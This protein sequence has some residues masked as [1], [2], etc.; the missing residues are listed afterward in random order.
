MAYNWNAQ[1][2][3]SA[4]AKVKREKTPEELQQEQYKK[5]QSDFSNW[6]VVG[7]GVLDADLDDSKTALAR[8]MDAV[9]DK[10]AAYDRAYQTM[11]GKNTSQ[12]MAEDL[13]TYL[14][15]FERHG[16]G[17]KRIADFPYGSGGGGGQTQTAKPD[18]QRSDAQI[19][20]RYAG[21]IRKAYDALYQAQG[22]N[23]M[24]DAEAAQ[25]EITRLQNEMAA[26]KERAAAQLMADYMSAQQAKNSAAMSRKAEQIGLLDLEEPSEEIL[27]ENR[28][29]LESGKIAAD[30]SRMLAAEDPIAQL[31]EALAYAQGTGDTAG[32]ETA[33][34]ELTRLTN[35]TQPVTLDD[36]YEQRDQW[37]SE[38]NNT[39]AQLSGTGRATSPEKM[40]QLNA[41]GQQY[42]QLTENLDKIDARIE[43]KE[44]AM[45]TG[46]AQLAL[47]AEIQTYHEWSNV[48]EEELAAEVRVLDDLI[49]FA[50]ARQN[51]YGN[52]TDVLSGRVDKRNTPWQKW[53]DEEARLQELRDEA[54]NRLNEKIRYESTLSD[55]DRAML[56]EV[57]AKRKAYEQAQEAETSARETLEE[58]AKAYQQAKNET[59]KT[60]RGAD[61]YAWASKKAEAAVANY[62]RALAQGADEEE[63]A[64]LYTQAAELMDQLNAA[65]E[66]LYQPYAEAVEAQNAAAQ[67][68]SGDIAAYNMV[69]QKLE[70]RV[71]AYYQAYNNY[72]DNKSGMSEAYHQAYEN[73]LG[74]TALIDG[75]QE[76]LDALY[77]EQNELFMSG[78]GDS[79]RAQEV[80]RLIQEYDAKVVSWM[81]ERANHYAYAYAYDKART[82]AELPDEDRKLFDKIAESGYVG[83]TLSADAQ[84]AQAQLLEK[85][86]EKEYARIAEM[87]QREYNAQKSEERQKGIEK[88]LR[89]SGGSGDVLYSAASVISNIVSAPGALYEIVKQGLENTGT[90]RSIDTNALGFSAQNFTRE[91]RAQVGE[92]LAN[93]GAAQWVNQ[94]AGSEIGSDTARMLYSTLMSG[95]DSAAAMI[96][97]NAL[98]AGLSGLSAVKWTEDAI[99]AVGGY[100]LG[101]TAAA[102]SMQDIAERGGDFVQVMTGGIMAGVFEC[103]FEEVSIEKFYALQETNP[104]SMQ[105]LLGNIVKSMITNAEE[106][107]ATEI[108]NIAYDYLMLGSAS[109]WRTRFEELTQTE[110]LSETQAYKILASEMGSQIGQSALSGAIMGAGFGAV[111]SIPSYI[112]N[113]KTEAF[114][115]AIQNVVNDINAQRYIEIS[116]RNENLLPQYRVDL[117]YKPGVT[118]GEDVQRMAQQVQDAWAKQNAEQKRAETEH[119]QEMAEAK[120]AARELTD[121]KVRTVADMTE[122]QSQAV[123]GTEAGTADAQ[124]AQERRA[125]AERAQEGTRIDENAVSRETTEDTAR[126]ESAQRRVQAQPD[127]EESAYAR[128][129]A[130]DYI[131]EQ[132]Q[133]YKDDDVLARIVEARAQEL[134]REGE[135]G[136]AVAQELRRQMAE[137]RAN[138]QQD[139]AVAASEAPAQPE[140][141]T[142]QTVPSAQAGTAPAAQQTDPEIKEQVNRILDDIIT[143][144]KSDEEIAQDVN[145]RVNELKLAGNDELAEALETEFA[146]EVEEEREVNNGRVYSDRD[147]RR[148]AGQDSAEGR[149][150]VGE[151]TGTAQA[152]KQN[153]A[154]RRQGGNSQAERIAYRV[155][156]AQQKN[157][158]R[159]PMNRI[160]R[161]G[162]ASYDVQDITDTTTDEELV[163]LKKIAAQ[164]G[165]NLRIVLGGMHFVGM[166]KTAN[167][168]FNGLDIVVRA[169]SPSMTATQIYMHEYFHSLAADSPGLVTAAYDALAEA[170]EA[171]GY[172]MDEIDRKYQDAYE[173]AYRNM[174]PEERQI[175]IMEEMC[176]DLYAGFARKVDAPVQA[177]EA[178]RQTV[179]ERTGE[180]Y[181]EARPE[182]TQAQQ[183]TRDKVS[184]EGDD[185][186]EDKY[187]ARQMDKWDSLTDGARIKVGTVKP[188]SALNQVGLPAERMFFDVGKIRKSMGD[189]QDHLTSNVLKQIPDLLNDPIVIAE[190]TRAKN[191]VNVYGNLK[192]ND[193]TPVVVG[194]VMRRDA[195]GSTIINNIRTIHA[196]SDFAKNINDKTV[197]YLNEDRKRTRKWFH[198]CGNLNVPLAGTKFGLIRSISYS[199]DSVKESFSLEEPSDNERAKITSGMSDQE[200][201]DILRQ[202]EMFYAPTYEG[203]AE[204]AIGARTEDLNSGK[205]S[206]IQKAVRQAAAELHMPPELFN[207]D[208]DLV[209]YISNGS[210]DESTKKQIDNAEQLVRL[211]PV[212]QEAVQ[213]AV[214]IEVHDNRYFADYN[215]LYFANLLGGYIDGDYFIPVRFGIKASRDGHNTLYVVISDQAIKKAEVVGPPT[216][217]KPGQNGSRSASD[218]NIAS[219]AKNVKHADILK[220]LPDGMLTE[221]QRELKWKAIADTVVYTNEKNDRKY[222]AFLA[223]GNKANLSAMVQAAAKA[224]GYTV[225]AYHGT[226]RADRVGNVFRPDRATS[227]PMAFFTDSREIAE[228]YS[229]D[230]RDTSLAY[231]TDYDSYET[232]F[233]ARHAKTG[234]DFAIYKLWG[235]IPMS[236]RAKI[237]ERAKHVRIDFDG[238]GEII[239][240]PQAQNANGGW[241]YQVKEFRGDI[242]KA[243]NEQW[244]NSGN[245]FDQEGDYLKV[246]EMVGVN[247]ALRKAGFEMPRYMDPEYREE[248]VYDTYLRIQNPFDAVNM[249]DEDFISGFE[250]F[251]DENEDRF[252]KESAGADYWDKNNVTAEEF[253][254]RMRSD[255]ENGLTHA[256][257]SIPD[258]MTEYLKSLGYDGIKDS[259][260]K[261]GGV[262]HTVW[263]PFESEQVKSADPVTYDDDGKVIPLSERF[264]TEKEDI[265]FALDDTPDSETVTGELTRETEAGDPADDAAKEPTL[266]D[267]IR[268]AA[269]DM[270]LDDWAQKAYDD[271]MA[272]GDKKTADLIRKQRA[273]AKMAKDL[274]REANR[275]RAAYQKDGNGEHLEKMAELRKQANEYAKKERAYAKQTNVKTAPSPAQ[276]IRRTADSIVKMF[277]VRADQRY[278]YRQQLQGVL[279]AIYRKGFV[280]DNDI[281]ALFRAMFDDAVDTVNPD[282]AYEEVAEMM[283]DRHIYVSDEVRAEFGDDWESFRRAMWGTGMIASSNDAD[284]EVDDYYNELSQKN[285]GIFDPE[286]ADGAVQLQAIYDAVKLGK[287]KEVSLREAYQMQGLDDEKIF[288]T[289]YNTAEGILQQFANTADIESRLTREAEQRLEDARAAFAAQQERQRQRREQADTLRRIRT[290]LKM[291]QNL[292]TRRDEAYARVMSVQ[293]AETQKIMQTALDNIST[294]ANSITGKKLNSLLELK[295][296]YEDRAKNNPNF[297][298][299][300]KI[301]ALLDRVGQV[302]LTDFS[303]EDLQTL[304]ETIQRISHQ[305]KIENDM[306]DEKWQETVDDAGTAMREE[307]QNAKGRTKIPILKNYSWNEDSLSLSRGLKRL[308]DWNPGSQMWRLAEAFEQGDMDA[309]AYQE[310]ADMIM[311]PFLARR[312]NEARRKW[313]YS[314]SV[315]AVD[316]DEKKDFAE[317]EVPRIL[318]WD[319]GD[320]PISDEKGLKTIKLK[321]TQMQLVELALAMKNPDNMR[322]IK[323]GGLTVPDA[324]YMKQGKIQDAYVNGET[325][326]L[327]PDTVRRI[328]DENLKPEG[329]EFANLLDKYYNEWAKTKINAVSQ[330]LEGVD[331]AITRFYYPIKTDKAYLETSYNIFDGTIEGMGPLKARIHNATAPIMLGDA[332]RTYMWHR[333]MMAKYVGYAIPVRNFRMLMNWAPGF[334]ERKNN[335]EIERKFGSEAAKFLKDFATVVETGDLETAQTMH[336]L[337]GNYVQQVLN[338]N[339]SSMLKQ[340]AAIALAGS[341]YGQGSILRGLTN[342]K[343]QMKTDPKIIRIY[344]PYLDMRNQEI[345]YDQVTD[346]VRKKAGSAGNIAWQTALGRNWMNATDYLANRLMWAAAEDVV[347]RQSPNLQPGTEAEIRAGKDLYYKE[348]ARVFNRMTF[349]TQTNSNMMS[350]PNILRRKDSS[351]RALTMFRTDALQVAGLFREAVGQAQWAKEN[352]TDK[353]KAAARKKVANTVAGI[354]T[355][356]AV[357]S[358]MG[359]IA[360]MIRRR[361]KDLK[362]EDGNYDWRKIGKTFGVEAFESLASSVLM[363][364]EIATFLAA[365]LIE[366]EK[367]FDLN[368]ISLDAINDLVSSLKTNMKKLVNA[369]SSIGAAGKDPDY[370]FVHYDDITAPVYALGKAIGQFF[371]VPIGNIEKNILGLIGWI[372]PAAAVTVN[373]WVTE[374]AKKDLS[375]KQDDELRATLKAYLSDEIG[376]VSEDAIDEYMRLYEQFGSAALPGANAPASYTTT[377]EDGNEVTHELTLRDI[378][379]WDST[380]RKTMIDLIGALVKSDTYAGMTDDEKK[381]MLGKVASYAAEAGKMAIGADA[382]DWAEDIR[383][384]VDEGADLDD[385]LLYYTQES[386]ITA[387]K[388]ENGKTIDGSAERKRMELLA[389]MDLTDAERGILLKNF[390]DSSKTWDELKAELSN[391][392]LWTVAQIMGENAKTADQFTAI[393]ASNLEDEDKNA[394][395]KTILSDSGDEALSEAQDRGVSLER[396][397]DV[398]A[399]GGTGKVTSYIK[400]LDKGT[401]GD[402]AYKILELRSGLEPEEDA[403][404][405][406]NMQIYR[407]IAGSSDFKPAEKWDAI[408]AISGADTPAAEKL[409][410]VRDT[411]TGVTDYLDIREAG[412]VDNY[413]D[414]TRLGMSNDAAKAAVMAVKDLPELPE[415]EYYGTTDRQK[416]AVR[417]CTNV[418]DQILAYAAFGSSSNED[419]MIQKFTT[420]KDYDVSPALYLDFKDVLVDYNVGAAGITQAEAKAALDSMDLTREQ[421]AILWQMCNNSWKSGKNPYSSSVGSAYYNAMH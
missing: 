334:G 119:P 368:T 397:A 198:D 364:S 185:F 64:A 48:T 62:N 357:S 136:Q 206:L 398:Y 147:G 108:A 263:V 168:W 181:R 211:I 146:R 390:K 314:A 133:L 71:G 235:Y 188:G 304:V 409:Y 383:A 222:N 305:I 57:E 46:A 415:G 286:I 161:S 95:L 113:S 29:N 7:Q 199:D 352:G 35:P 359:I 386:W 99:H 173:G 127:S 394:V 74:L 164:H 377:D 385:A 317:V 321:L 63:I 350:K 306:L 107:G 143:A 309:Y 53:V 121:V 260:G 311:L 373:D 331:R 410:S 346:I 18:T 141:Y 123:A 280:G 89:R 134:D 282:P 207:K 419:S 94:L 216:P 372:N 77:L 375:G 118:T 158:P 20:S 117:E 254:E 378:G 209:A 182:A 41:L 322:H 124:S 159:L 179:Q 36:L 205:I 167:G 249:I 98:G 303:V 267:K 165:V 255:L 242:L 66:G 17:A 236:E 55:E 319:Q 296:A 391:A 264:N 103:L 16:D 14:D 111:G 109:E 269:A 93:S 369:V 363:G 33:Q 116:D 201:E 75:Y 294:V 353:D 293:D 406:T 183:E 184:L 274:R 65:Y 32:A 90:Y 362:D 325:V 266:E 197:L 58:G 6:R 418:D 87:V 388:D 340:F 247:D 130:Q 196:R 26:E 1:L 404:S 228:N 379:T 54:Q 384:A 204:K 229:R 393:A 45:Q 320:Q 80:Q 92:R 25:R 238:D 389:G 298:A 400:M 365:N 176:A 332:D 137:R 355:S 230:K 101:V 262:E 421:K 8:M 37:Q 324:E 245:L 12:T 82:L 195:N 96:T 174:D 155:N 250:E 56:S 313:L 9:G 97:G 339:I 301:E 413:L 194:V 344:T 200:R 275:E 261:N 241:E 273:A 374:S 299:D 177:Q 140:V 40:A 38:L 3:A 326:K 259:G 135:T 144:D 382:A 412:Q 73:M 102:N 68:L 100:L 407:E 354:L 162:D 51:E 323:Y 2:A 327:G 76:K 154:V 288:E 291:L 42:D 381:K 115:T 170:Y 44:T 27:A 376:R 156:E 278:S 287:P 272:R 192:I 218:I 414:A 122:V 52:S 213:S 210:L 148:D 30:Q 11:M 361:D 150:G 416:A 318:G 371:G 292:A 401:D 88:V 316:F 79:P 347:H 169:D 139:E 329:R 284:R 221:E 22:A 315:D 214:G 338:A 23:K 370:W 295:A 106:E 277:Q 227:G 212:L 10:N 300:P 31:Q 215:T 47:E 226:G 175:A 233:R 411:G 43:A 403:N 84:K 265:R 342:L 392:D 189:H 225:H 81:S 402:L 405:V 128:E 243:L 356:T 21:D 187:F 420:A 399:L 160:S 153:A 193:K 145:D 231:D 248:K 105:D 163:A 310:G 380:Y 28:R 171:A 4:N 351:I 114:R 110:G 104:Q 308:G 50:R 302:H 120:A 343:A 257:T 358:M 219:L 232:Q 220:Y 253:V 333:D 349:D 85:Y 337:V 190:Y 395:F 387:D 348:V 285:P 5:N 312:N 270:D 83:I 367:W 78:E 178:V 252:T 149:A 132:D 125:E 208:M 240:D 408:A 246:L 70:D 341:S 283:R 279:E 256:W 297:V 307:T 290:Q 24:G 237:A 328:V 126:R 217:G 151:S 289:M 91:V 191:T 157:A 271:A 152:A 15:S 172:D 72:L 239:Y 268:A 360:S 281:G 39:V 86:G 251:A 224:A 49:A 186:E 61:A 223:K 129:E 258:V 13:R 131:T 180:S 19:E 276:T 59:V 138:A 34:R 345:V 244:L 417:A 336:K 234:K 202:K 142:D 60:R 112:R 203:Q 67:A 330:K 69:G 396:F 166:E 366:G 335:A